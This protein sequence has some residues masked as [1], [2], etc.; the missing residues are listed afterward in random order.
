MST[1]HL[2]LGLELSTEFLS[3]DLGQK[4]ILAAVNLHIC[5]DLINY[6]LAFVLY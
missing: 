2:S 5:H 6:T 1:Y 4:A 3:V